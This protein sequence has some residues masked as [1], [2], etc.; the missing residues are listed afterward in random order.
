MVLRSLCSPSSS[1]S[2]SLRWPGQHL[3][4][5]SIK[6][7]LKK[8]KWHF[9]IYCTVKN[10]SPK[11][12]TTAK[13]VQF[14]PAPKLFY[15]MQKAAGGLLAWP[16]WV[17]KQSNWVIDKIVLRFVFYQIGVL[18][19]LFWSTLARLGNP[20]GHSVLGITSHSAV[21]LLGLLLFIN[22]LRVILNGTTN[23][24]HISIVFK[25]N[26]EWH[27][28]FSGRDTANH[29]REKKEGCGGREGGG[30]QCHDSQHALQDG[31]KV[32]TNAV[33][34]FWRHL[35]A[36]MAL[37]ISTIKSCKYTVNSSS[38]TLERTA[39]AKLFYMLSYSRSGM[40]SSSSSS[41]MSRSSRVGLW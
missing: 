3:T 11:V 27:S 41:S 30:V 10:T 20:P 28:H 18:P 12:S 26:I 16:L 4:S 25:F 6:Q 5:K 22:I 14:L 40:S 8:W 38:Y 23:F 1:Y 37:K 21:G 17:E 32:Q 13:C 9:E 35:L 33:R 34:E 24:C 15:W 29:W 19:N 7:A 36:T 39:S 2:T 31:E